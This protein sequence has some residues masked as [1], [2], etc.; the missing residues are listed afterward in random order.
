M[1][2]GES[3]PWCL[4]EHPKQTAKQ[5]KCW[6]A[7]GVVVAVFIPQ[8]R[9]VWLLLPPH[10]PHLLWRRNYKKEPNLT[11][12]SNLTR[13]LKYKNICIPRI[14][15]WPPWL[16]FWF[17]VKRPSGCFQAK[18]SWELR[19]MAP[20]TQAAAEAH[21]RPGVSKGCLIKKV[22]KTPTIKTSLCD[23][24]GDSGEFWVSFWEVLWSFEW[25][26]LFG[27][28]FRGSFGDEVFVFGTF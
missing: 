24:L 5:T 3:K 15:F 8:K 12:A 19:P 4:G 21:D 28:T 20:V 26:F 16:F 14:N 2:N 25:F 10:S 18:K 13:A 6:R 17:S 9:L 1:T 23:F 22:P 7:V 27:L 11:V